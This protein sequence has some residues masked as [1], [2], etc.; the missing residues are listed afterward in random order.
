MDHSCELRT[1]ARAA[2]SRSSSRGEPWEAPES[3]RELP[4][5]PESLGLTCLLDLLYLLCL[6]A[7]RDSELGRARNRNRN[8]A[9]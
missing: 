9:N 6:T 7:G 4:G 1:A 8:L 3:S 5:A 2:A